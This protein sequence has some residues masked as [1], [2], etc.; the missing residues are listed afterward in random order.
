MSERLV[1]EAGVADEAVVATKAGH[2]RNTDG[3]WL[4]LGHP[5]YIRNQALVSLDRLGVGSIDLYQFHRPDPQVSYEDS[6]VAFVELRDEGLVDHVGISNVTVD[7]PELAW[8]L[9]HSDVTLPI[10]GTTSVDH[11]EENLGA[12]SIE[13]TADEYARLC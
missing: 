10:P 8:L 4:T 13:L 7:Q 5:D 9:A 1:R 12:A 11:L 3:D 2:I 6:I